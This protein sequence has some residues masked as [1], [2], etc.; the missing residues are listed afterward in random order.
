MKHIKTLA[1][2]LFI[3]AANSMSAQ[4]TFDKWPAIKI[5]HEV[6]SQTFHPSEEGNLEPIKTRSKELA[7]KA[8][9]LSKSEIPAEYKTEAI[10]ASVEKLQNKALALHNL[11]VAK[12][13]DDSIKKELSD[14]H[15]IFHEIVGLCAEK[16]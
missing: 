5:F 1:L 10:S 2:L 7:D 13:P 6:M 4:S 8:K 12:A 11:I 9:A 15:D 14:L 16:K 3:F